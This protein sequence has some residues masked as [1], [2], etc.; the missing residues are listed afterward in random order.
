MTTQEEERIWA[1]IEEEISA[2]IP[3]EY[4]VVI[5]KDGYNVSLRIDI[6]LGG[7]FEG[8]FSTTTFTVP[9]VD[10]TH[11]RFAIHHEDFIDE[12]GKFVGMQDVVLGY[13]EFDKKVIVKTNDSGVAAEIFADSDSRLLFQS[14]DDY[15]FG[16]VSHHV[17]EGSEK[18]LFLELVIEEAVTEPQNLRELFN[19]FVSILRKLEG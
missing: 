14:L 13:P 9:L 12:I 17:V 7:G 19:V 18:Q 16:I 3:Y 1:E 10:P 2:D 4:Q 8:G 5:P 15:T 6:D 11:F